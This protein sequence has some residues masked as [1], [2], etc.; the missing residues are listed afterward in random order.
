MTHP[1]AAA[2]F[3]TVPLAMTWSRLS[4]LVLCGLIASGLLAGFAHA[5]HCS[6]EWACIEV[7]ESEDGVALFARNMK[8]YPIAMTVA[9]SA[10]NMVGGSR[11]PITVDLPG[12]SRRPLA[13]LRALTDATGPWDYRYRYDW[14][15]GSLHPDH[16]DDYLYRLPYADNESFQILQGYGSKFS[17]RG[18]EY[19]TVDFRMPE[20]TPVYAAREGIVAMI[21]EANDRGC[22]G[23]G[24]GR[25]ANYVV[26]LHSDGTTGEY[27]HLKKDGALVSAGEQVE[28]GQL[29]A[30]SGNTGN[31]TVA[32][33]HFGVYRAVDW[34]R[35]QSI[36]VRFQ[37]RDGVA[38][39]P[40][41]GARY[42]NP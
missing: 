29:I 31:S 33:L 16:D 37:T 9:V 12:M 5:D 20:G 23:P 34:G 13:Q 25:F 26:I 28:R 27:Y 40:R 39:R 32:H 36:A 30:L 4:S 21:E 11:E 7:L 3:Q 38:T 42:L 19:Y 24:C 17:H 6:R 10:S 22:W 41:V 15:V 18:L 2:W 8:P 1:N 35:T 14:T